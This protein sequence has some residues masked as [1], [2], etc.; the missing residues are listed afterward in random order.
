MERAVAQFGDLHQ[1]EGAA[2]TPHDG[3]DQVLGQQRVVGSARSVVDQVGLG[4]PNEDRHEALAVDLAEQQHRLVGRR[5]DHQP[6]HPHPRHALWPRRDRPGR[7][8]ASTAR[9]RGR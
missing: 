2:Q 1:V 5:V 6:Q 9:T 8:G 7:G 3:P 4:P